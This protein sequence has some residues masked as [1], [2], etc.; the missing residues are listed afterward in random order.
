MAEAI[1]QAKT[2]QMQLAAAPV[3]RPLIQPPRTLV[4]AK[5]MYIHRC[6]FV[7]TICMY[8]TATF[9]PNAYQMYIV[10]LEVCMH[11]F[12]H[13][14]MYVCM[15]VCM[16]ACMYVNRTPNLNLVETLIE[17]LNPNRNPKP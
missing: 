8:V 2:T 1:G 6:V 10:C 4:C 11:V 15:H 3:A 13:T 12:I 14:C 16:H 17:T 5:C 9:V 7:Y